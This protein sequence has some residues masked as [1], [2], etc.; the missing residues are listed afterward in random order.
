MSFDKVIQASELQ[1]ILNTEGRCYCKCW[2]CSALLVK[3]DPAGVMSSP[4]PT[5]YYS[6]SSTTPSAVS[7]TPTS[8]VAN[9]NDLSNYNQD[10]EA[11]TLNNTALSEFSTR[12][13]SSKEIKNNNNNN[14]NNSTS[15]DL[16]EPI[17]VTTVET[18]TTVSFINNN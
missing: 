7:Y 2:K 14:N 9:I 4:A 13:K 17:E 11:N 15:F 10:D 16:T 6:S 5:D 3:Y 18:L 8:S 12:T 1:P